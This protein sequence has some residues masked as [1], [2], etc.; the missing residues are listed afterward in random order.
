SYVYRMMSLS[1]VTDEQFEEVLESR[2]VG[3]LGLTAVADAV[4]RRVGKAREH[5]ERCPHCGETLRVRLR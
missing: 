5:E 3:S 2:A 1:Q 4:K